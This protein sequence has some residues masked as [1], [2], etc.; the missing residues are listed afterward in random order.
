MDYYFIITQLLDIIF[1][2]KANAIKVFDLSM[3]T[4]RLKIMVTVIQ[5]HNNKN[6]LHPFT[7]HYNYKNNIFK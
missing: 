1:L 7:I 4:I 3:L 6:D 5:L 2:F